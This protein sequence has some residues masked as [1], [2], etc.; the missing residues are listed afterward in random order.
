MAEVD[1]NEKWLVRETRE[2][3]DMEERNIEHGGL[4]HEKSKTGMERKGK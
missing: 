2:R 4:K 3:E 1:S